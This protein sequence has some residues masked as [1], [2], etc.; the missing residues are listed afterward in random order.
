MQGFASYLGVKYQFVE[1][2]WNRVCGDLTGRNACLGEKGFQLLGKTAIR[3]DVI[4]NGLTMLDWRKE[5]VN[6]SEPTF[7][8]AVW[9]VA[10]ASSTLS[11]I[12]P[13]GNL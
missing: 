6:F 7:P 4:A 11:P 1:S 8:S 13:S 2:D 10:K 12:H 3:G 9:L 5:L